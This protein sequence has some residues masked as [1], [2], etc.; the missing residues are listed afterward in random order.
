[1]ITLAT[2]HQ[3]AEHENII[4]IGALRARV[5]NE[6]EPIL[7]KRHQENRATTFEEANIQKRINP[8]LLMTSV[9]S[10]VVTATSYHSPE[11]DAESPRPRYAGEL[12]KFARGLDYH[13]ILHR[14]LRALAQGLQSQIP[15]LT[16]QAYVDTGPLVDRYLAAQAGLGFYGR[17]NCLIMPGYG[18]CV[19]FGYLLLN[20]IVEKSVEEPV[21]LKSCEGCGR[22][23]A[24]CPVQALQ[25]PYQ[26][27]PER[28]LSH[29][30]QRKESVPDEFRHAAGLMLYGCDVCQKV[31]PHNQSLPASREPAMQVSANERWIDLEHLLGL[32]NRQFNRLYRS[33]AFGWRGQKILQRNALMALGNTP[34][35]EVVSLV[36]PFEDHPRLELREM[37]EWAMKQ[38]QRR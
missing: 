2:L 7:R 28:C 30:L 3:L 22:C 32:S 37:A 34:D 26:I 1:M 35:P 20:H 33:H 23:Q 27:Q 18:S 19:V 25:H 29:L 12:A 8:F 36:K 17:N 5:F 9:K 4:G 10:I 38:H 11:E 16:W 15:D 6:L 13:Q 24:A 14:Q 31:C 21:P